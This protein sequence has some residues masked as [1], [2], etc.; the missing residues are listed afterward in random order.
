MLSLETQIEDMAQLFEQCNNLMLLSDP[1]L[2]IGALLVA[3]LLACLAS[4]FLFF[5]RP[6]TFVFLLGL[7][8]FS[9][10]D[11]V[12]RAKVLANGAVQRV[13][14]FSKFCLQYLRKNK[15]FLLTGPPLIPG[16]YLHRL[17]LNKTLP[18]LKRHELSGFLYSK[19][20]PDPLAA[21]VPSGEAP[22]ELHWSSH[23]CE[24]WQ[25]P[26][27][28]KV[29]VRVSSQAAANKA[30]KSVRGDVVS[31]ADMKREVVT[32]FDL[33]DVVASYMYVGG[34]ICAMRWCVFDVCVGA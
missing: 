26:G 21:S 22:K 27:V 20:W 18:I 2:S 5:V 28:L 16:E 6:N 23:W 9:P 7:T 12:L 34:V 10:E 13:T 15:L 17:P 31:S 4:F 32:I 24:I 8:L 14:S 11:A 1:M 29:T 30:A 33:A 19:A 3:M 25:H